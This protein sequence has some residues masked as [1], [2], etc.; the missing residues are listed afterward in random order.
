MIAAR[1]LDF[2]TINGQRLELREDAPDRYSVHAFDPFDQTAVPACWEFKG[3]RAL[4]A[5]ALAYL[6]CRD[7]A[8]RSWPR[9]RMTPRG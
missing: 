4:D 8:R 3:R 7:V 9:M 5:A 1:L 2:C 6:E